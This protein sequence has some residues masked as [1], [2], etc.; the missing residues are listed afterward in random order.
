[1]QGL[2]PNLTQRLPSPQQ[3]QAAQTKHK[4]L[5]P[6]RRT[7]D[8]KALAGDPDPPPVL[9]LYPM[10]SMPKTYRVSATAAE[11]D[12][13]RILVRSLSLSVFLVLA[14]PFVMVYAGQLSAARDL[15]FFLPLYALLIPLI[16]WN[17]I[18]RTRRMVK[19]TVE[20]YELTIDELQITRTQRECP[21]MVIA[22]T[23]VQRI[24]ERTGQGFRIETSDYKQNIWVPK[25]LEGYEEV[26]ALLLSTTPAQASTMRYPLAITYGALLLVIAGFFTVMWSKQRMLVTTAGLVVLVL[27]IYS[28]VQIARSWPN[29]SRHTK[30]ILWITVF[31]FLAVIGRIVAVWR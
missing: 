20:T 25:E 12:T 6:P 8:D 29:L 3:S 24:A 4:I 10:Y 30:R 13:N 9:T 18:R 26:K 7:Q 5:R 27:F 17:T 14:V 1:M 22:R 23:E 2:P 19:N 21:T 28:A 16:I 31:P 15:K 11:Q